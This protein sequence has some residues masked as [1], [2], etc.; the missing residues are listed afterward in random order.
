M[1]DPRGLTTTYEYDNL[2][3][4]KCIKDHDGN[5]VQQYD[6]HYAE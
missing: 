1:T 6:Y 5:I 2:N 3:R 4:L